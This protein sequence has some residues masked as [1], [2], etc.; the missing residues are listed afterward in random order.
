M[1]EDDSIENG[2]ITAI[3]AGRHLSDSDKSLQKN[4]G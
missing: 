4:P 3:D 1:I 2:I